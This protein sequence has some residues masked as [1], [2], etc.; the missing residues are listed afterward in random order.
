MCIV[1]GQGGPPAAPT[2]NKPPSGC[3]N[4][5]AVQWGQSAGQVHLEQTQENYLQHEEALQGLFKKPDYSVYDDSVS[6]GASACEREH[7]LP[8]S[9]GRRGQT[10]P[11]TVNSASHFCQL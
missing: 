9:R 5:K 10:Q 7:A 2:V 4:F 6:Q 8:E 1:P 3:E 11:T